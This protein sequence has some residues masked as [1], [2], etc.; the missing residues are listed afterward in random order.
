MGGFSTI[1]SKERSCFTKDGWYKSVEIENAL[2]LHYDVDEA[3]VIGI[4]DE[5]YGEQ[6]CACIVAQK[7][8]NL[9]LEKLRID[10]ILY[11]SSFKIPRYFVFLSSIPLASTGFQDIPFLC[12][13]FFECLDVTLLLPFREKYF[14]ID[15]FSIKNYY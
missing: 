13:T 7:R 6:V 5:M 15:T 10:L 8:A 12:L 2:L 11:M 4:P 14:N 1:F 3:F 9:T